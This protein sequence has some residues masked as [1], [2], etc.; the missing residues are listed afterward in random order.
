ML[1]GLVACGGY[2]IYT[3]EKMFGYGTV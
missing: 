2:P 1:E 3:Q